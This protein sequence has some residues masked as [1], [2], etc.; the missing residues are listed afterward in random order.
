[1]GPFVTAA[2]PSALRAGVPETLRLPLRVET[3]ERLDPAARRTV[4]Q[5]G[6]VAEPDTRTTRG[7][8]PRVVRR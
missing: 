7:T 4:R 6:A 1:M 5:G 8:A 3:G 2:G